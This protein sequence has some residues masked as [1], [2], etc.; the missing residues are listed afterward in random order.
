M[1]HNLFVPLI[2]IIKQHKRKKKTTQI[3]NKAIWDKSNVFRF[4]F[5]LFVE[6]NA[7]F[8]LNEAFPHT[9]KEPQLLDV[10]SSLSVNHENKSTL[11]QFGGIVSACCCYQSVWANLTPYY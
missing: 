8:E 10:I 2:D 5:T 6:P 11:V 7:W 1:Q 3:V 4:H 9:K